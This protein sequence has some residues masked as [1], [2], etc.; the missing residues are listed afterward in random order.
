MDIGPSREAIIAKKKKKRVAISATAAVA[1]I[2]AALFLLIPIRTSLSDMYKSPEPFESD[3]KL[4][5][6][7]FTGAS[8]TMHGDFSDDVLVDGELRCGFYYRY[9]YN[10]CSRFDRIFAQGEAVDYNFERNFSLG[11]LPENPAELDDNPG[12]IERYCVRYYYVDPDGTFR[13]LWEHPEIRAIE[14]RCG[15]HFDE[16]E[17]HIVK[18]RNNSFW[19]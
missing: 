11:S 7:F 13:L 4:S 14:E 2:A 18:R 15:K 1:V 8:G 6:R 16:P 3:G 5:M 10:S 9:V 12:L 17:N 19:D